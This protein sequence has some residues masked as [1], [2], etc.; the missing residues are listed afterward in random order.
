[1]VE[2]TKIDV[3]ENRLSSNVISKYVDEHSQNSEQTSE[4]FIRA[5]LLS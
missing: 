4:A 1:M 5:S 3:I 2:V